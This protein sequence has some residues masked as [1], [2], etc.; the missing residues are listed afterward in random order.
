MK[1]STEE[2]VYSY[3]WFSSPVFD[4]LSL[5][6][7]NGCT[8]LLGPNG[9][10]KST[11]MSLLASAAPPRRGRVRVGSWRSDRRRDLAPLR[12][13]VGWMPQDIVPVTG[14]TVR[15]Q[16]AYHGWLKGMSRAEA[17]QAS[18]EALRQTDLVD[19]ADRSSGKL[20]GGQTR[21]LG[22]AQTIVHRP[23]V[24]LLDEPT[25]GLDPAQRSS[26]RGVLSSLSVGDTVL[27]ST[28]QTSD[29]SD[30][31]DSVVVLSE[32]RSRFTGSAEAFLAHATDSSESVERR[33]EA[34]YT[35]VLEEAP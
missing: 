7:P 22:L 35:A 8:V 2:I 24:L 19:L 3:G 9:A 11:L 5:D 17:W 33:A 15:E 10:G 25:A 31:F 26:F 1:L 18:F 12:R 34:A 29:L 14:L 23:S 32:G 27:V 4:G 20:S 16:V 13:A 21:R 30:L 6:I 28:H